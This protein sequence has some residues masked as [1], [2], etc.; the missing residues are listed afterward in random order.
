MLKRMI[1][2]K[3][4]KEVLKE[5]Q[6][7]FSYLYGLKQNNKYDADFV[8]DFSE[9]ALD[10][11]K[12]L[13]LWWR[14]GINQG[15]IAWLFEVPV[16][17]VTATHTQKLM[18][19]TKNLNYREKD[20]F[21]NLN[22]DLFQELK[23]YYTISDINALLSFNRRLFYYLKENSKP[24][25]YNVYFLNREMF[26]QIWWKEGISDKEIGE[27]VGL[28]ERRVREIRTKE[29]LVTAPFLCDSEKGINSI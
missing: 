9:I 29:W 12:Y 10:E 26:Y 8:L 15:L 17:K 23:A 5:G 22:R 21:C 1:N 27:F 3:S 2:L 18:I 4:V 14:E 13:Q 19:D 25:S 20:I 16:Q 6:G 28:S 7:Y 24:N 11:E